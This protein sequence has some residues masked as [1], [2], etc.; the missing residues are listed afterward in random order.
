MNL[1]KE[2]KQ[3][4]GLGEQT[5]GC[6]EGGGGSGMTWEFGVSRHILLHLEWISNELLPC[7]T[8]HYTQMLMMEHDGI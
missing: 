1:S 8:G 6:P 2:K 4:H 5:C 7:S 3:T